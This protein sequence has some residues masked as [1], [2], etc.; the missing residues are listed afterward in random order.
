MKQV[1]FGKVIFRRI[2][3]G[4]QVGQTPFRRCQF[5]NTPNDTR[6]TAWSDK[7]EA[8]DSGFCR[9]CHSPMWLK[10]KP[11]KL[12]DDRFKPSMERGKGK[13]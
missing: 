8:S 1:A 4:E 3:K 12:P 9:F 5:C 10:Q 11:E 13:R 2:H 7:T 6:K